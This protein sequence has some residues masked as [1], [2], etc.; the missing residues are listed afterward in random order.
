MSAFGERL[1]A[2]ALVA[3][4]LFY[5]LSATTID[6]FPGREHELITSRS[7]PYGLTVIGLLCALYIA[8]NAGRVALQTDEEPAG[9]KRLNW[10]RFTALIAVSVGYSFILEGL[11]FVVSTAG[12]LAAGMLVMGERRWLPLTVAAVFPPLLFWALLEFALDIS[13]PSFIWPDV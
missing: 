3:F 13:L 9:R 10:R 12:F 4:C 11:G 5:G 1:M 6:V 8:A 2:L 7:F